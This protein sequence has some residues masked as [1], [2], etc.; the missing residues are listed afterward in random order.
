MTTSHPIPLTHW[1]AKLRWK[2]YPRDFASVDAVAAV[3][4]NGGQTYSC[5]STQSA[6]GEDDGLA[7]PERCDGARSCYKSHSTLVWLQRRNT[8]A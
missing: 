6:A 2:S 7:A 8:N 1:C 4:W 5:L 3:F